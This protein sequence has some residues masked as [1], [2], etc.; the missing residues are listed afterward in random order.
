MPGLIRV[1]SRQKDEDSGEATTGDR[2]STDSSSVYVLARAVSD[3]LFLVVLLVVWLE[4][5]DVARLWTRSGW[6]QVGTRYSVGTV[7]RQ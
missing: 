3:A 2:M 5:A 7:G 4:L 6:C 1:R